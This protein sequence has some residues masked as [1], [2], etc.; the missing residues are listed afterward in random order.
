MQNARESF[1]RADGH[2]R[3]IA[4]FQ[5]FSI[6]TLLRNGSDSYMTPRFSMRTLSG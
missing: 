5:A 3:Y 1:K 2:T 4:Y 6:P